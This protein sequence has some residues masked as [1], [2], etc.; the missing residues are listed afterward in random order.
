MALSLSCLLQNVRDGA[1]LMNGGKEEY[2]KCRTELKRSEWKS[3]GKTLEK[4]KVL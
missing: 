3:F 4:H 1:G 2:R